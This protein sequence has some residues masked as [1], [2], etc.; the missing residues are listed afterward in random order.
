MKRGKRGQ[1]Y[2]L[3]AIIIIIILISLVGISNYVD[4]KEEP[5]K[6]YSIGEIL[7][8]EGLNI[9]DYSLYNNQNIKTNID[10]FLSL[11]ADYLDQNTEE[12]ISLI[13]I[14]GNSTSNTISAEI[15]SRATT[16]EVSAYIGDNQIKIPV[17]KRI[18]SSE[19]QEI[20]QTRTEDNKRYVDVTFNN[21]TH[22]IPLLDDNN[23]IF[24]MS[25][26]SGF[27]QYVKTNINPEE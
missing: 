25:T 20:I 24:I 10:N 8:L 15:Y 21:V 22:T 3:G 2:I 6:L 7:N 26:G 18:I 5:E 14:Y 9:I 16:G 23:F 13:F 11:F 4:V 12:D 1:F 27:D 17:S 19:E